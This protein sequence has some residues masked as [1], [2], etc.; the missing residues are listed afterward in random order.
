MKKILLIGAN[1]FVGK[2]IAEQLQGK[3]E[4]IGTYHGQ[5]NPGLKKQEK[6]D[7]TDKDGV[8]KVLAKTK[9][10]AIIITAAISSTNEQEEKI[11]KVNVQGTQN[12]VERVKEQKLS[13]KLIFF[14]TEQVF[15]GKKGMYT[16]ED[17]P[18]PINSYG[19]SKAGAEELV[20]SLADYIILRCSV[21]IGTKRT[22]DHNNFVT[23]F[24]DSDKRLT[25]FKDVYRTTLYVDDIPH[26][27]QALLD[28]D[29]KGIINLSN[30]QLLSYAEMAA[31]IEKE[32][33]IKKEY[34]LVE[35]NNPFIPKK[36]GLK[37][38]LLRSTVNID[39]TDFY[40]M[41][42]KMKKET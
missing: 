26:I 42:R 20:K 39:I 37:N 9:P 34:D 31:K 22:G 24:L 23:N 10:D 21:L 29:Y 32:F 2:R 5:K 7:I 13:A 14:S 40:N 15:D 36:L 30:N 8:K 12:L 16:E 33:N 4:L 25:I 1:S 35:C 3:Y 41:L 17:R 11:I 27:I 38:E 18:F 19:R 6:L 28:K